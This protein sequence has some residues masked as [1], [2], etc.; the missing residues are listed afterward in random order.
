MSSEHAHYH[1][2]ML[3]LVNKWNRGQ[4]PFLENVEPKQDT[5][6]VEVT[7]KIGNH[8]VKGV[9]N[10][11]EDRWNFC[12]D[13]LA[14]YHPN[15]VKEDVCMY[16]NNRGSPIPRVLELAVISIWQLLHQPDFS[17]PIEYN[18]G[19]EVKD[20]ETYF[21]Q[22]DDKELKTT[23]ADF[24]NGNLLGHIC[25]MDFEGDDT[26]E[27]RSDSPSPHY[28]SSIYDEATASPRVTRPSDKLWFIINSIDVVI[29]F[30]L[31][32]ML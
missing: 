10:R 31:Y 8:L 21:D 23:S 22:F 30:M 16:Y 19:G 32:F 7:Y 6:S 17:D 15:I 27:L 11:Y 24:L 14:F 1:K 20:L 25:D 3:A 29:L 13:G 26:L 4:I 28:Y 5:L 18:V 12:P 2:E 9:F